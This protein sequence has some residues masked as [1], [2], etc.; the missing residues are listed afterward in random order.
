MSAEANATVV[1]AI[2]TAIDGPIVLYVVVNIL[3]KRAASSDAHTAEHYFVRGRSHHFRGDHDRA[4]IEFNRAIELDPNNADYYSWRGGRYRNKGYYDQTI[5]D[6]T[7]AIEIDP[8]RGVFYWERGGAH[9]P[10]GD[11][12]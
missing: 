6:K 10:K 4:I 3:R 1:A 12:S 9:L 5:A 11:H 7:R 8:T 2:I